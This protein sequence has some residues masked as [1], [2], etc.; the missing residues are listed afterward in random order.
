[1]EPGSAEQDVQAWLDTID[2]SGPTTLHTLPSSTIVPQRG[3]STAKRAAD[4]LAQLAERGRP[5]ELRTG[6]LIGEGGMGLV[7]EAEQVALGRTVAVKTVKPG[8]KD[9]AAASDLLREAWVTGALE[10]PNVVPV[11][12]L[13]IDDGLMPLLILKRVDGVE[14]S[15][16]AA[17]A[18]EIQRR[19]G[20]SDV[21]AWN[22]GILVQVLNALR[23]AH[24]R[25]VIHRDLKPSNVMIG[26]FGE[27][28]LLDWGIALSLRDDGT[29]RFPLVSDATELAGTPSY[30]APEMLLHED[31]PLLSERTDV[32]LAGAV[33]FELITGRTPHQGATALAILSSI[34]L[35][36]P[37]LPADAPAELAQICMRAM[38]QDPAQRFDSI[39]ALQLAIQGYLEHRGSSRL[40]TGAT[41]R[42]GEL[43][44]LASNRRA[45]QREEIYR[46][47]AICRFAF[48][49]ALAVW[50][51]NVDARAGLKQANVAVAQYELACGDPRAA[52]TLL[53]EVED[54]SAL[55]DE[56]QLAAQ[57]AQA[58]QAQLEEL[59]RDVDPTLHPNTRRIV[60]GLCALFIFLPTAAGLRP[61]MGLKTHLEQVSFALIC[62]LLFVAISMI[63]R[64]KPTTAINRRVFAGG[65][66]LFFSQAMLAIGMWIMGLS[67]VDTQVFNMLVWASVGGMFAIAIDGWL[68]VNSVGYFIGFLIAARWPDLRMFVVSA[69]NLVLTANLLLRWRPV[70]RNLRAKPA[71]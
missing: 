49:E 53:T 3:S 57:A 40:T 18:S 2:A 39:E 22:L 31:A 16:L 44:S 26:N 23:F 17:D 50:R 36:K 51:D 60:G 28:Y 7:H 29:G 43:I 12:H 5:V 41:V 38:H 24:A 27:V 34:A 8:R 52:V 64:R 35:S 70:T 4:F 19:F 71:P 54:R 25:G 68:F 55:L 14:W 61:D 11:H 69:G 32:Y 65:A 56:A 48:H 20:A 42:L 63:V 62:S 66:F 10:H 37:T 59:R 6:K 30:M 33:L 21:L 46:Q 58:R 1:M 15:V 45:D 13:E 47:L 9:A 67:I